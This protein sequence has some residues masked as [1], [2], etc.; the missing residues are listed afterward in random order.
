MSPTTMAM[1]HEVDYNQV[2]LV[3]LTWDK[4]KQLRN[5]ELRF[6]EFLFKK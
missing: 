1:M 3:C 5:N 6:G 2:M 4:V